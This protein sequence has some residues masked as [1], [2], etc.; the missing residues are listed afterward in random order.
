LTC[1]H[2]T[3]RIP[4]DLKCIFSAHRHLLQT[5]QAY[6]IGA[7]DAARALSRGLKHPVIQPDVSRLIVDLNRSMGHPALFSRITRPFDEDKK[8]EILNRYYFP[9]RACV[10]NAVRNHIQTGHRVL[11]ISVHSFTP[12]FKG[13]I[14]KTDI[15]LLFDPLRKR[16]REFCVRLRNAL[17]KSF[18]GT[19]VHFNLPYRGNT[20]GLTSSMRK[21]W[22]EDEYLGIE[23]EINQRLGSSKNLKENRLL[24]VALADALRRTVSEF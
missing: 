16:E 7:L 23:I 9:Y 19:S 4:P 21:R 2:A 10:E 5:H 15:G 13:K 14:R 20:D 17:R 11:H 18:P 8:R 24:H 6:D 12:V 1:E 3:P 22:R